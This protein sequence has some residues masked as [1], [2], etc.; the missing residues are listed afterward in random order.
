MTSEYVQV[1]KPKCVQFGRAVHILCL[2]L[3]SKV[4]AL[5]RKT[6]GWEVKILANV[7]PL[8]TKVCVGP[9]GEPRC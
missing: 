8:T 3:D 4:C 9:V 2:L 6:I 5:V 7:S 1:W